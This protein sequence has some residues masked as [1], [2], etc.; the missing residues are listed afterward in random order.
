MK[1]FKEKF[2]S[3]VGKEV[4]M[5]VTEVR[6]PTDGRRIAELKTNNKRFCESHVGILR[7]F[8]VVFIGKNDVE[9]NLLDKSVVSG[10]ID[11]KV[12]YLKDLKISHLKNG[13]VN[14]SSAIEAIEQ[15]VTVLERLKQELGL[16]E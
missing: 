8:P 12:K 15:R 4:D 9:K 2:P 5:F 14:Y 16:N 6:Y 7:S 3:L 1:E 10:V 11:S 13:V